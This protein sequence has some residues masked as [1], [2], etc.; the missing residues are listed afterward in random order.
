[1]RTDWVAIVPGE[2]GLAELARRLLTLAQHPGH[3]RTH[4]PADELIVPP[5]LAALYMPQPQPEPPAPR[6]RQAKKEKEGDE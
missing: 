5:Y 6:R 2:E 1:M 4:G 3:V